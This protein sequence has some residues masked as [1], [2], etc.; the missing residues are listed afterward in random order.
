MAKAIPLFFRP[1]PLLCRVKPL[2]EKATD[3]VAGKPSF[4]FA[5]DD[6]RKAKNDEKPE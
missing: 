1:T 3:A 2:L 6:K 5:Q 4:D